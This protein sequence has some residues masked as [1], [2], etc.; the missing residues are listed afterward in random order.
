[1][2]PHAAFMIC[3]MRAARVSNSP[4][5][6]SQR[7]AGHQAMQERRQQGALHRL[8]DAS[9]FLGS[10]CSAEMR[11]IE[12]GDT[13]SIIL[14]S[15]P[16]PLFYP[17][18]RERGAHDRETSR[19]PGAELPARMAGEHDASLSLAFP[20]CRVVDARCLAQIELLDARARCS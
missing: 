17:R 18:I 11:S 7:P 10:M 4:R 12:P 1:M 20:I 15:S 14:F 13:D 9:F 3:W 2:H 6:E 8:S 16:S 19:H 5:T